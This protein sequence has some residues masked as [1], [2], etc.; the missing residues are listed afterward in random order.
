M[1]TYQPVQFNEGAPLDPSLLMKLQDNVTTAYTKAIALNNA[2][3]NTEYAIKSDCDKVTIYGLNVKNYVSEKISVPTFSKKA[4]VVTTPAT[5]LKPKE[6]IT[7]IVN[8]MID[9]QFTINVMSS[10]PDR[11]K[12]TIN[13][14][15]SERI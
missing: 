12:M 13:W 4:I 3:K 6:Q 5:D 1:S 15:I 10:D 14:H 8:Q 11:K 9:G 2:S 7:I